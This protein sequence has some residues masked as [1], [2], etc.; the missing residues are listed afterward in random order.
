MLRNLIQRL[1]GL[2]NRIFETDLIRR[3]VQNS[4]YLVSATGFTA[5]L[6]MVQGVFVFR[7]L[8]VPGSGVFAAIRAFTNVANRFASFRINELVVRY[9]RLYEEKGEREKAASVFKL[10]ALFELAGGIAAFLLIWQLAPLG[11]TIFGKDPETA[12][13]FVLYGTIVLVNLIY[14]TCSGVLQVFDHFRAIAAI[15]ALQGVATLGLVVI[16]F[17]NNGGIFEV[18]IAYVLGKLVGALGI[19]AFAFYIAAKEWTGRWWQ[20][21]IKILGTERRSLFT[22][23]FSTNLSGTISL[24]AKDSEALWIAGFLGTTQ[25]GFYELAQKLVGI[26][27]LPISPLPNTTYPELSREIARGDWANARYILRRGSTLAAYYSLP[28]TLG[29]I[30][31]GQW[32]IPL[33]AGPEFLPAYPLLVILLIG[34]SFVN[35]FYWNRVAL[36]ALNRPVFPTI[37]N[38]VGMLL[39]V[40]GIFLL[41][42]PYGALAFAGLLA[43]YYIFTVGIAA[44]RVLL[45]LRQNLVA[46]PAT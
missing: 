4:G 27:Q 31:F 23:A 25:A 14:D 11:A 10:A 34:Y 15:T 28:I 36:L 3:I 45:D 2:F 1:T 30:I 9:I 12:P 29:L 19:T 13:L 46:E 33:Y 35:V 21:P 7:M 8:E 39:K 22:F 40:G 32:F 43:G 18:L 42:A 41:A 44:A 37:V 24:I 26:L 16:A 38:F 20:T 17:I 6:G 5:A